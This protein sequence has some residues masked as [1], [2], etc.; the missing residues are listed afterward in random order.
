VRR[1]ASLVGVLA[2]VALAGCGSSS[3][4]AAPAAVTVPAYGVYSQT[5]V[6]A[7]TRDCRSTAGAVARDAGMFLA[8]LRP[9]GAY[10]ADLY[11]MIMREHLAGFEADRCDVKLLGTALVKAL[12]PK[13]R[14][15]LV[16]TLP[17]TMA[18]TV[19]HGLHRAAS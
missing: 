5:K 17:A 12:T 2:V 16:A 3:R 13:Q 11:Y 10:P 9:H 18:A 8:H 14:H 6:T 1:R 4:H 15:T 7:A 19:G